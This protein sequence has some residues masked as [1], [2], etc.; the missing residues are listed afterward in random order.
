[1]SA[2]MNLEP[3][4]KMPIPDFDAVTVAFGA[5]QKFFLNREQL[6]GWYGLYGDNSKTPF[7]ACA[8]SLFSKG[9]KLADYGLT[10]KADVD[11]VKAFKAIRALMSSFA[12]KHEE[13]IGTVA[14]ALANWCDVTGKTEQQ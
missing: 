8:E 11:H 13:K 4:V 12:P 5:P 9:G 14:V 10:F 2:T 7:H 3:P 1:M 6:G